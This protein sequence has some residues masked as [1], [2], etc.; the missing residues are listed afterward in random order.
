MKGSIKILVIVSII[1]ALAYCDCGPG[2]L[3]CKSNDCYVCNTDRHYYHD[4]TTMSCVYHSIRNCKT[5]ME[6][7]CLECENGFYLNT[8]VKD[9]TEQCTLVEE[10]IRN[11]LSYLN[12]STC[13]KCKNGYY[14]YDNGRKCVKYKTIIDILNLKI[15]QD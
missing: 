11:C 4:K 9:P 14:I 10:G 15:I 1:T 13:K 6:H 7:T 12:K 3:A 2:C 5:H 8:K